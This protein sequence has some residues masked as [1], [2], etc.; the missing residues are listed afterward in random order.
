MKPDFDYSS[1]PSSFAHCMNKHCLRAKECLRYQMALRIP[2]ERYTVTVVNPVHS[3]ITEKNCSFFKPDC[4]ILFARGITH[5]LER[6]PHN[7]AIA[8]KQQMLEHFGRT[9]FYR[10]WRK[11]RLLNPCQQKYIQQLFIQRGIQE[12]PVFDEYIEQYEW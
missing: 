12:P 2:P 5:L 7:D 10:L 1:S 4:L 8:I 9:F 6:I 3:S 11:E